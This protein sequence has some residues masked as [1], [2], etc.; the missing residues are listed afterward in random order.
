[1]PH[2]PAHGPRRLDAVLP[3]PTRFRSVLVHALRPR[4]A[5]RRSVG[6]VVHLAAPRAITRVRRIARAARRVA[7]PGPSRLEAA[8]VARAG[9][10]REQPTSHLPRR[11]ELGSLRLVGHQ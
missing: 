9:K 2:L 8:V 5:A 11:S 10:T 4:I 7:A 1:P 3:Y 6:N